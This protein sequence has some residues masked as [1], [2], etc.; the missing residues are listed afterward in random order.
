MTRPTGVT[1]DATPPV[2]GARP[3]FQKRSS[4]VTSLKKGEKEE[5]T[6][7]GEEEEEDGT[8]ASVGRTACMIPPACVMTLGASSPKIDMRSVPRVPLKVMVSIGAAPALV[9]S[10]VAVPSM[11]CGDDDVPVR[12]VQVT[13]FSNGSQRCEVDDDDG[14]S[15]ILI[16][17]AAT[18]V[19]GPSM[20]AM[21][22]NTS[23]ATSTIGPPP[24]ISTEERHKEAPD[25]PP[26]VE[27]ADEGDEVKQ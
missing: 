25:E 7:V 6:R 5:T 18:C 13:R 9:Q 10:N 8:D 16:A 3:P 27:D 15:S 17:S 12:K 19:T 4:E 26:A 14:A 1:L 23:V 22:S 20:S 11:A 24:H 2:V 21:R